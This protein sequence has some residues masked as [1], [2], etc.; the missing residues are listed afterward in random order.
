MSVT[1]HTSHGRLKIELECER[2]PLYSKNFLALCASGAYDNVPFHRNIRDFMLHGGDIELKK[3]K[4]GVALVDSV[5]GYDDLDGGPTKATSSTSKA[6]DPS[7]EDD[8][9]SKHLPH[10]PLP[11]LKH[12]KRGIVAFSDSGKLQK[13]G[14]Q[15]YITYKHK[16]PELDGRYTII[17]K[18]IEGWE[19]LDKMEGVQVEDQ[20]KW[21]PVE[22]MKVLRCVIHA[23][24]VAEREWEMEGM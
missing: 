5:V 20:K 7:P 12:D 6:V 14:S 23:N 22:E 16:L 1:L 9:S 18:V 3:G 2:L 13:V 21:K 8:T 19:T 4:G 24:P 10:A 17:G 11:E 15:F